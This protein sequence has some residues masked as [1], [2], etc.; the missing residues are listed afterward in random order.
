M[1]VS[2]ASR[3]QTP[4]LPGVS[5]S[6][7]RHY[8]PASA[9]TRETQISFGAPIILQSLL[10]GQLLCPNLASFRNRVLQ[11]LLGRH[12]HQMPAFA[13]LTSDERC[14]PLRGPREVGGL[15]G[16]RRRRST[17]DLALHGVSSDA[18]ISNPTIDWLLHAIP[19]VFEK[20][21]AWTPSR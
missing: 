7:S 20:A 11:R 16:P 8:T 1:A 18:K 17:V 6:P 5:L 12:D 9:I 4:V 15:G 21:A 13:A 2:L 14:L 10:V 19:Y 3:G